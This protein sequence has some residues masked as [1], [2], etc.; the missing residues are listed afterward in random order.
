VYK[1]NFT[2]PHDV[3]GY[4]GV[5]ALRNRLVF[6]FRG[7]SNT[8]NWIDNLEVAKVTPSTATISV[9]SDVSSYPE[10]LNP[11]ASVMKDTVVKVHAGFYS[12][13]DELR[14]LILQAMTTHGE[15][16]EVLFTGHSLGGA[17]AAAAAYMAAD[18]Y[19]FSHAGVHDSLHEVALK[20]KSVQAITF[21]QPRI[22]NAA[23]SLLSTAAMHHLPGTSRLIRVVHHRDV[24]P[25]VPPRALEYFHGGVEMFYEDEVMTFSSQARLCT[26]PA[27]STCAN[28][29]ALPVS[30]ADHLTYYS[31]KVSGQC[32]PYDGAG[33]SLRAAAM[34]VKSDLPTWA[35]A[36]IVVAALLAV[37]CCVGITVVVMAIVAKRS[38]AA[39]THAAR[40]VVRPG[41]RHTRTHGDLEHASRRA[42]S[43]S[44]L[45]RAH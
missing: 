44:N 18:P 22:G 20:T 14:P 3:I 32:S 37:A 30:V 25:H 24:V 42:S 21:G 12:V 1:G 9:P 39:Q 7:S 28:N 31:L 27:S 15:G 29:E 45:H 34:E 17:V 26:S 11:L 40:G 6:S 4:W 23:F 2:G 16:R 35:I 38:S 41:R 8:Q 13:A 10:Y 19:S 33:N 43:R 36:V 5:D